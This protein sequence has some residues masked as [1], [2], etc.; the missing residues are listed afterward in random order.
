MTLIS[1]ASDNNFLTIDKTLEEE[2]DG[3]AGIKLSTW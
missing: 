3:M 2:L 1:Q